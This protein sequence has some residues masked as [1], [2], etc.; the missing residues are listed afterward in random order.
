MRDA[1]NAILW[2]GSIQDLWDT[3][4]ELMELRGFDKLIY[5]TARSNGRDPIADGQDTLILHRYPAGYADIVL[6]ERLYLYSPTYDWASRHIGACSWPEARRAAGASES[7]N[8]MQ[9]R[10]DELNDRF[11]LT[12]GYAIAVENRR[13]GTRGLIG[14][15]PTDGRSQP[16]ADAAWD[17]HGE[18]IVTLSNLMHLKMTVLPNTG[19]G[20][21]L[22]PRQWETLRW[23]S[24]GKTIQDIADIMDLST[25]TVEKH[26]RMAREALNASTTAHAVQ[27]AVSLNLL[28]G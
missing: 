3:Y 27:R 13:Q 2:A 22:T 28:S 19:P 20:R 15:C 26:L 23:I 18:D 11:G 1:V 14:L 7:P 9:R 16:D 10:L 4:V 17:E 5:G 8:A 24:Q 12:A 6:G 25:A 21:P